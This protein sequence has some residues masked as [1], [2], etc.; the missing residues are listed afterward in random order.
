MLWFANTLHSRLAAFDFFLVPH[1]ALSSRT[2]NIQPAAAW[3]DAACKTACCLKFTAA[4]EKEK[5]RK[6]YAVKRG[7]REAHG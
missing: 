2:V 4:C 3:L 1:L 7:S 5:K 6:D